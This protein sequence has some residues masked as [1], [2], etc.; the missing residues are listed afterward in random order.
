M[1]TREG[2]EPTMNNAVI[3]GVVIGCVAGLVYFV[4][5]YFLGVSGGLAENIFVGTVLVT[6]AAAVSFVVYLQSNRNL[7]MQ[8]TVTS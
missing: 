1:R 3:P 8:K 4:P 5:Q 7:F 2:H 6:L